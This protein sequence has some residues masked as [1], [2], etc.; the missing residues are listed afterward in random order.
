MGFV[1]RRASNPFP[2]HRVGGSF[3]ELL[4]QR[5]PSTLRW[6][7]SAATSCCSCSLT[8][9]LLSHPPVCSCALVVGQ[10]SQNL[11][12]VRDRD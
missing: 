9:L 10:I 6:P 2:R 11:G 12:A 1:K 8:C 5:S 4:T 7:S 3:A